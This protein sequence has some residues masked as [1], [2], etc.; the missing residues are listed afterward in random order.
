M[1]RHNKLFFALLCAMATQTLPAYN[2]ED[3][4]PLPALQ[5]EMIAK[6]RR[7]ETVTEAE[8]RA[9]TDACSEHL[10]EVSVANNVLVE[11]DDMTD[12]L[13]A[14]RMGRYI[15]IVKQIIILQRGRD[16]GYAM[17]TRLRGKTVHQSFKK[18]HTVDND[19]FVAFALVLNALDRE[20]NDL[21]GAVAA[22]TDLLE[23]DPFLAGFAR[24]WIGAEGGQKKFLDAI[25]KLPGEGEKL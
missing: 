6:L 22:Y 13:E 8:K 23:K 2:R 9:C 12:C 21:D 3:A 16:G 4:V 24:G 17:S 5:D 1:K 10:T 15:V 20:V 11:H 7:G 19:P 14:D 18:Q 25:K